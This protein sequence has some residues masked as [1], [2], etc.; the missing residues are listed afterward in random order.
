AWRPPRR[1]L[2]RLGGR[3]GEPE[4]VRRPETLER[5]LLPGRPAHVIARAALP[6]PAV[7]A[8]HEPAQRIAQEE[9]EL[10]PAR[11][12]AQRRLMAVQVNDVTE[13]RIGAVLDG[14]LHRRAAGLAEMQEVQA[15]L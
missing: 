7:E 14:V 11:H 3:Q 10:V 15:G 13:V 5:R 9:K 2:L 8:A 6:L 1:T 4:L 12:V